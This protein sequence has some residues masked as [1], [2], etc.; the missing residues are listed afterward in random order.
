MSKIYAT[1]G[2]KFNKGDLE[3]A[4]QMGTEVVNIYS[5]VLFV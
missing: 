5:F 2:R 3:A 1:L 4:E